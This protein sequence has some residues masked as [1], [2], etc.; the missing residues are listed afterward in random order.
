MTIVFSA[1]Y[2][3]I[4]GGVVVPFISQYLKKLSYSRQVK[5]LIVLLLCVVSGALGYVTGGYPL[6]DLAIFIP[7]MI[8]AAITSYELWW[9]KVFEDATSL[10]TR[11]VPKLFKQP[12]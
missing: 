5:F 12:V 11:I 8:S 3:A 7:G 1:I 6:V 10:A 4:M 2:I 9:K